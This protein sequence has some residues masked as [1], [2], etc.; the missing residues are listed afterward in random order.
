MDMVP[1]KYMVNGNKYSEAFIVIAAN[2]EWLDA[3]SV[4]RADDSMSTYHFISRELSMVACTLSY[5]E[6]GYRIKPTHKSHRVV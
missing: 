5:E 1:H 3:S 4:K 6:R 2:K